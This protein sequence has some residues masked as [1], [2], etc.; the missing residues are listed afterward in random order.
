[1]VT[2]VKL[3]QFRLTFYHPDNRFDMLAGPEPVRFK[4]HAGTEIH[5]MQVIPQRHLVGIVVFGIR[6]PEIAEHRFPAQVF[7]TK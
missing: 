4:I 1:M 2:E 7:Y 6:H 5:R 3:F